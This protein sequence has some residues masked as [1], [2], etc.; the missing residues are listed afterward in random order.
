MT[1]QQQGARA[2]A[3]EIYY[4]AADRISGGTIKPWSKDNI[5][6]I[7]LAHC[8]QD[9]AVGKFVGIMLNICEWTVAAGCH[10]HPVPQHLKVTTC[11]HCIR[12]GEAKAALLEYEERQK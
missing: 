5:E 6:A 1:D 3:E 8:P 11:V 2:A 12:V 10:I 7:I 4:F 9:K